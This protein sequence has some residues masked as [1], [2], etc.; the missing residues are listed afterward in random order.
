MIQTTKSPE[1]LVLSSIGN[2]TY[3]SSICPAESNREAPLDRT[4]KKKIKL[5]ALWSYLDWGQKLKSVYPEPKESLL[6]VHPFS[7]TCLATIATFSKATKCRFWAIFR[8]YLKGCSFWL[9][10]LSR[11]SPL[12]SFFFILL[13]KQANHTYPD[14]NKRVN[15]NQGRIYPIVY[16]YSFLLRDYQFFS[17]ALKEKQNPT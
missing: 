15:Y 4:E 6:S 14:F 12:N 17:W 9:R 2:A 8:K 11:I 13:L 1:I 10:P 16:E 3:I 7:E 5:N